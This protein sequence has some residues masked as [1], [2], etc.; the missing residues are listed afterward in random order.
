MKRT[1]PQDQAKWHAQ[2]MRAV[3]GSCVGCKAAKAVGR[4]VRRAIAPKADAK[5]S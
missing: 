1:K 2:L 4:A 5:S 3:R